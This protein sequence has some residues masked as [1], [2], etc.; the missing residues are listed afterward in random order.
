MKM[1]EFLKNLFN[2]GKASE[3][4]NI[5]LDELPEWFDVESKKVIE[6]TGKEAELVL[7][8]LKE[9]VKE[10]EN[11]IEKLKNAEL[12][13]PNISNK[14]RHFM[15]GNREA[16]MKAVRN[17]LGGV[18]LVNDLRMLHKYYD[19]FDEKLNSFAKSTGRSY[20]ILQEFLS[21]ESRTVAENIND[22]SKLVNRLKE[23]ISKGN[24]GLLDAIRKSIDELKNQNMRKKSLLEMLNDKENIK[25]STEKK[26][27]LLEENIRELEKSD[28]K[29]KL[30]ELFDN[31][32]K[33]IGEKKEHERKFLSDFSFLRKPISKYTR[34]TLGDAD[35]LYKYSDKPIEAVSNDKGVKIAEVLENMKDSIRNN[36]IS[37]DEKK[38]EK[39]LSILNRMDKDYFDDYLLNKERLIERL[40]NTEQEIK[41]NKAYKEQDRLDKE[42]KEVVLKLDKVKKEIEQI[43]EEEDKI[44]IKGIKD[45]IK[46]RI[47]KILQVEVR[48]E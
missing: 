20:Y 33:I 5:G 30:A 36:Q 21:A 47:S 40:D 48:I 39:I 24:I 41:V 7:E 27:R 15:E 12:P 17:F 46:D 42:Q 31:K 34:I 18:L 2:K 44:D 28:E 32:K 38:K 25:E 9:K 6:H 22:I 37:L 3:E 29:K 1:F 23:I 19:E 26:L 43:K 13:N 35:L 10:I 14:E 8:Q 4:V 45:G 11:N 16:Y